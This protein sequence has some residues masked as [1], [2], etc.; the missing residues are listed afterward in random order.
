MEQLRGAGASIRFLF[1]VRA[2]AINSRPA[3]PIGA[4]R[5][6]SVSEAIASPLRL[7]ARPELPRRKQSQSIA[8][9]TIGEGRTIGAARTTGEEIANLA[10]PSAALQ[11]GKLLL[12]R[13]ARPVPFPAGTFC[14]RLPNDK[15]K[16]F[17]PGIERDDRGLQPPAGWRQLPGQRREL[18][19]RRRCVWRSRNN[20]R[21]RRWG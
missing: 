2:S 4:A 6:T 14:F 10:S 7:S 17:R 8:F 11:K 9:P 12:R 20:S 18:T 16:C 3:P 1:A 5:K 13:R 15:R 19:L 21:S